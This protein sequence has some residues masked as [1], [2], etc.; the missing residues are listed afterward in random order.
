MPNPGPLRPFRGVMPKI[1]DD[2]FVADNAII[3]G[4]VEIGSGSSV[5]FGVVIRG[6]SSPIRIGTRSNIQDGTIIH[7]DEDAPTAIGDEVTIGHGCIIHG[8]TVHDGAQ[9]SMGA[10]VLSHS[11]IGPGAL[12]GAGAL[13]PEGMTVELDTVVMGVPAN[14]RRQV[15]ERDRA[16]TMDAVRHYH[17]LGQ[18]YATE[19]KRLTRE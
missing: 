3:T 17:E 5:W 19:W 16:R 11:I 2:A 15:E 4:D 18:E 14:A 13:V 12:V 8:T 6:D 10:I 9:V 1:A 7:S